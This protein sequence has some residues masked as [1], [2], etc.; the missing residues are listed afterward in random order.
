MQFVLLYWVPES[1]R[2]LIAQDRTHEALHIL[3]K[4]H[5]NGD[6]LDPTVM[7]EYAEIKETIRL[8]HLIKKQTSFLDFLKT[9]GNRYRLFLIVTLGFFSQW[10][11]GGL[12]AYYFNLILKSIGTKDADTSLQLNGALN[13]LSLFVSVGCAFLVDKL[14]RR[15]LFLISSSSMLVIY[16]VWTFC[17]ALYQ[18]DHNMSAGKVVVA[19]IFL[20]SISY[21]IAWS[22]LLV[23]YTVEIL[24]FKLRAK[25]LMLMNVFVQ[26]ALVFNQY[27]NPVGWKAFSPHSWRFLLIYYCLLAVEFFV[28]AWCYVETKG[29]TLEEIAKI[30]DGDRAETGIA[31]LQDVKADL[32]AGQR[33]VQDVMEKF[34]TFAKVE[35]VPMEDRSG[36]SNSSRGGS[37][38]SL[39]N[40]RHGGE[41][42]RPRS[43]RLP[44]MPRRNNSGHENLLPTSPSR[45]E[46]FPSVRSPTRNPARPPRH[47][48]DF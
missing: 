1:P 44:A 35:S 34:G 7:F 8:E 16:V 27:A 9:R 28:I 41:R 23:A 2:W 12:V 3:A 6:Q 10:S 48:D 32:H 22:G 13:I 25:G 42:P 39:S 33:R 45:V 30:F 38:G 18:V 11:G 26:S 24:P 5:A 20:Y 40:W 47:E 37:G 21:A 46:R 4:F 17:T 14:G 43:E 31:H 29:P 15:P 19:M 36:R